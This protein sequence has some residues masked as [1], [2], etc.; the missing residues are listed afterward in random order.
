MQ[1]HRQG[2]VFY[3]ASTGIGMQGR[4]LA[5]SCLALQTE[6]DDV[7]LQ[8]LENPLQTSSFDY[9]PSFSPKS[10]KFSRAMAVLIGDYVT[11]W[12]SGTASIVNSESVHLGDIEKQTEQTIGNIEALISSENF[13]RHGVAKAGAR[14]AD[15]AKVRVYI[16]HLED[17]P[18]CRAICERHFGGLPA[19]YAVADVCR[20]NLLV[21]IEGV[22]FSQRH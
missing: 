20:S 10:P 22:A 13:Q 18:K 5:A 3:P 7:Q 8:P 19:I 17:Y 21:E 6:R 9:A 16:K 4:G 15:L 11:T 14:L 12:I 2:S 1:V